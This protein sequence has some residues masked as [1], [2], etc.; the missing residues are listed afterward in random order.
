MRNSILSLGFLGLFVTF[1]LAPIAMVCLVAFTPESYLSIP[2]T[3]FSLRWFDAVLHDSRFLQAFGLSSALA[4]CAATL[5]TAFSLPAAL[6]LSRDT[7]PGKRAITGFLLSPLLIPHL[8]LGVALLK[9]FSDLNIRGSFATM[10]IAH[11]VL[12]IPFALR[13]II[14]ASAGLITSVENAAFS[15]GA[16]RWTVLRRIVVP[17]LAPGLASGWIISFITSFDELTMS[18]FIASPSLTTLPVRLYSKMDDGIDPF[19]TAVS[20]LLIVIAVVAMFILDRLFGLERFFL[21]SSK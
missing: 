6:A 19:V 17:A 18:V 13:L 16:N 1:L 8:V 2:T 11:T 10:V 9:F 4:T 7:F 14:S 3:H 21:G 15:L 5:G 12:V 20:A